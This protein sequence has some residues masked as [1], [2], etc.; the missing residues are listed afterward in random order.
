MKDQ[1]LEIYNQNAQALTKMGLIT[2]AMENGKEGIQITEFGLGVS[3]FLNL[4]RQYPTSMLEEILKEYDQTVK[5]FKSDRQYEDN[6]YSAGT[7]PFCSFE[8]PE[9]E[10]QWYAGKFQALKFIMDLFK[11]DIEA[12]KQE[13]YDKAVSENNGKIH[14]TT[15][16]CDYCKMVRNDFKKGRGFLEE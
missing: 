4:A 6:N 9:A 5:N 10:E 15:C 7:Y 14:E 3:K 11:V 8:N 12:I 13:W 1:E 2:P 16:E